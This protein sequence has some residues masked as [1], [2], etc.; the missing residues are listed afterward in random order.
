MRFP[1]FILH[2]IFF[3]F[4]LLAAIQIVEALIG[5]RMMK[6]S[7][8]K[9]G[10]YSFAVSRIGE[11]GIGGSNNSARNNSRSTRTVAILTFESVETDVCRGSFALVPWQFT[12]MTEP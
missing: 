5:M 12:I 3:F 11:S 8:M 6:I 10:N 2:P 7:R 4:F 9:K 1:I